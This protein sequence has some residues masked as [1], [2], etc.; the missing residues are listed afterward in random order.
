MKQTIRCAF[1]IAAVAALVA[2]FEFGSVAAQQPAP[3]AGPTGTGPTGVGPAGAPPGG[4]RGRGGPTPGSLLWN[5]RCSGCHGNDSAGGRAPSLF[6]QQWADSTPDAHIVD[7]IKNGV[8]N[9]EMTG[10]SA[11]LTDEQIYQLIQHIRTQTGTP[12][13]PRTQFVESPDG[14]VVKSAKQTFK[15]ELVADGLMTPFAISFLPDGRMLVPE[16]DGRLQIIE[17]GKLTQ[18]K[19]TPTAHVQQDG[20]YFDVELHPQYARNGWIYLA[21]S[22]EL[23]GYVAPPPQADRGAAPAAPAAG[24][25]GGGGQGGGGRGGVPLVPTMTVIVRGKINKNT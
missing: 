18:V 14:T 1:A 5:E 24:A 21:Y 15:V 3:P 10:F 12:P 6:N 23:P 25:G 19:G 16:R 22:E 4:G 17:K 9:T 2:A 20:G 11:T 8:P 7:V 13:R